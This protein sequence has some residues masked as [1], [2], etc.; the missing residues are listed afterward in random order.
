MTELNRIHQK[1]S[2][3]D[4]E[5]TTFE[6]VSRAKQNFLILRLSFTGIVNL[7]TYRSLLRITCNMTNDVEQ[8]YE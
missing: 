8:R 2:T 6:F 7:L 3:E 4:T 1:S 5:L